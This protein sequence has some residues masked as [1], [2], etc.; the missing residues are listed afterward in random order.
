[1]IHP[2][3]EQLIRLAGA[4]PGNRQAQSILEAH[5]KGCPR[6]QTRVAEFADWDT[7]AVASAAE[8][9]PPRAMNFL[10]R[11]IPP[12]PP[13]T[14]TLPIPRIRVIPLHP[15][16]PHTSREPVR[17]AA[18]GQPA[19]LAGLQ[20]RATLYSE[21]PELVLRV[22][23]DPASTCDILHLLGSGEIRPDNVLLQIEEPSLEFVTDAD[24]RVVI[25]GGQLPDPAGLKW[26]VRLPDAAFLLHP[27]TTDVAAGREGAETE[28][29]TEDKSRIAVALSKT[30]DGLNLRVRLVRIEGHKNLE[31]VRLVISQKNAAAHVIESTASDP[32]LVRGLSPEHWINIRIFAMP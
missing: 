24:G 15:M 32:T 10:D 18:D 27:L 13:L 2:S 5:V 12:I 4:L 28:L 26:H 14:P 29:E 21:D 7:A 31:R 23:H 1:M 6:C 30:P 3:D 20:H 11:L 9:I 16:T 25:P 19:P 8:G 17:L 22:M